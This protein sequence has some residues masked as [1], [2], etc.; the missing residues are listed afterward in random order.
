MYS[1]RVGETV[2]MSTGENARR[3]F[4]D[5]GG[6]WRIGCADFGETVELED[7]CYAGPSRRTGG[8]VAV[9]KPEKHARVRGSVV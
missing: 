7:C 8:P 5:G 9:V 6:D 4:P 3:V 1:E 2:G